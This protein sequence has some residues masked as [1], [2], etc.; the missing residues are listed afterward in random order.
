MTDKQETTQESGRAPLGAASC[1]AMM[2]RLMGEQ[3]RGCD[4]TEFFSRVTGTQATDSDCCGALSRMMAG[5]C[6]TQSAV[7]ETAATAEEV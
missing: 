6:G 2:E 7:V 5:C 3:G 1:V 4:C